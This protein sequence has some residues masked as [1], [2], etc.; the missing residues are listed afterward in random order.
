MKEIPLTQGK[1]A[2]IDD[3][4]Y[5]KICT[6]KWCA[7]YAPWTFYSHGKVPGRKK[8]ISMHRFIMGDPENKEIDHINGNGLDNRKENLRIVSRQENGQNYHIYYDSEKDLINRWVSARDRLYRLEIL[9]QKVKSE[10]ISIGYSEIELSIISRIEPTKDEVMVASF[11]KQGLSEKQI[12]W[13]MRDRRLTE[14]PADPDQKYSASTYQID[15]A[16][17]IPLTEGDAE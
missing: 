13:I 12:S 9:N 4:D 5:E 14:I 6:G 7:Q 8:I 16:A 3:E 15:M 1:V 10:L 11:R 17:G 2:L